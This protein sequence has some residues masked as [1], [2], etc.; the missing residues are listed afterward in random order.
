MG[1]LELILIGLNQPSPYQEMELEYAD[2]TY[3]HYPD[4][5]KSNID[6]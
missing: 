6:P 3:T 2:R 1:L 4:E 5:Y